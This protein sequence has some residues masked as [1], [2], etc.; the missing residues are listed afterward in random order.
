MAQGAQVWTACVW[1]AVIVQSVW[2]LKIQ[3]PVLNITE[4]LDCGCSTS[5]CQAVFWYWQPRHSPSKFHF[6]FY[7]NVVDRVHYEPTVDQDKYKQG[8]KGG[9]RPTFSLKIFHVRESDAGRYFCQ[10]Q[11]SRNMPSIIEIELRPG[12]NPPTPPPTPSHPK[13]PPKKPCRCLNQGINK[14]P[15]G[16]GRLVLWPLVGVLASLAAVLIATL[17]YFSRLPKKCRHRLV[18]KRQLQ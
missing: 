17:F 16:C 7:H 13:K 5:N 6:L 3:Y 14:S 15:K 11:E 9:T 1:T 18:K 2:A 12:E 4:T 10:L 8:M